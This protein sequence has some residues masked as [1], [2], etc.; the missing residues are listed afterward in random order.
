LFQ[1][2]AAEN[3]LDK[4]ALKTAKQKAPNAGFLSAQ[5]SEGFFRRRIITILPIANKITSKLLLLVSYPN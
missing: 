1:G 2:P 3:P 5:F 4:S